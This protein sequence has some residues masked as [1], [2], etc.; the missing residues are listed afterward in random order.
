MPSK[1]T[2][3]IAAATISFGFIGGSD[4]FWRLLCDI[5]G[6]ARIDPL[7]NPGERADHAHNIYGGDG[8]HLFSL[9]S[10]SC[11]IDLCDNS[12]CPLIAIRVVLIG[13]AFS[14]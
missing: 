11:S 9:S 5:S 2:R 13:F 12:S 7:V 10:F 1:L 8:K 3:I 4:A 14:F 6:V